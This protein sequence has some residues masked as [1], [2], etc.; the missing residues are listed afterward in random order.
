MNPEN[1]PTKDTGPQSSANQKVSMF[2]FVKVLLEL[3]FEVILVNGVVNR[4]RKQFTHNKTTVLS[5]DYRSASSPPPPCCSPKALRSRG[6]ST[7]SHLG[8]PSLSFSFVLSCFSISPYKNKVEKQGGNAVSPLSSTPTLCISYCVPTSNQTPEFWL[9]PVTDSSLTE[10]VSM[11]TWG[12]R[13]D[14]WG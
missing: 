9:S 10:E 4:R 2:M 14:S 6:R 1:S 12:S 5:R 3:S 13:S 11:T 8:F 7:S